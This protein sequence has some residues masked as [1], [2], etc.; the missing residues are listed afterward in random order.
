MNPIFISD[1][2]A[3]G[4]KGGKYGKKASEYPVSEVQ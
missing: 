4:V 3:W 1:F 2:D